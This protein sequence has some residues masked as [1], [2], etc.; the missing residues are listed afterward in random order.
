MMPSQEQL[1]GW[2]TELESLE[3][4]A[5]PVREVHRVLALHGALRHAAQHNDVPLPTQAEA[6][7]ARLVAE[8]MRVTPFVLSEPC[9]PEL[10]DTVKA[11]AERT[12]SLE[13]YTGALGKLESLTSRIEEN[14]RRIEEINSTMVRERR[15]YEML[16]LYCRV[17]DELAGIPQRSSEKETDNEL[18]G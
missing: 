14:T 12:W 3:Q 9:P 15:Q 18:D 2:R 13:F 1:A 11:W 10:R 7:K 4:C 6:E 8:A 5:A 17:L 16:S